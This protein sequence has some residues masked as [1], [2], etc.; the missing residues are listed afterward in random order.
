MYYDNYV[1]NEND[2]GQNSY[3]CPLKAQ[4]GGGG[5]GEGGGRRCVGG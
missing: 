4:S 1:H 3:R 5:G 2:L